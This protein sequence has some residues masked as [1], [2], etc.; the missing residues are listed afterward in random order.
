MFLFYTFQI[1]EPKLPPP[2]FVP[3]ERG[4]GVPI[5]PYWADQEEDEDEEEYKEEIGHNGIDNFIQD[6]DEEEEEEEEEDRLDRLEFE[7]DF[8]RDHPSLFF[9]ADFVF[10][11]GDFKRLQRQL[12]HQVSKTRLIFPL[13]KID[14][15]FDLIKPARPRG[16]EP[17]PCRRNGGFPQ[18][19]A[20]GGA[21]GKGEKQ[22]I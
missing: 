15:R 22:I 10:P 2:D 6:D 20:A 11:G 16:G 7:R 12:R 8:R 21:R 1:R 14:F 13:K 5:V 9:A 17:P 19:A 4:V 18:A 3:T